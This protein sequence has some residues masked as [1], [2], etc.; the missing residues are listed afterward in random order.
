MISKSYVADDAV[1]VLQIVTPRTTAVL[2]VPI[3]AIVIG[4]VA[5]RVFAT[6]LKTSAMIHP[7]KN[8][9]DENDAA[10]LPATSA[11]AATVDPA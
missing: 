7:K 8:D 11:A 3:D 10:P 4:V 5:V 2:A 1:L 9:V 6:I